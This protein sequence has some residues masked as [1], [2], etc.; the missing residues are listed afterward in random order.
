MELAELTTET[1]ILVKQRLTLADD[2]ADCDRGAFPGSAAAAK[3]NVAMAALAAFD[4]ANPS[5]REIVL[6]L[7]R[8]DRD[9][10]RDE[11]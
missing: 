2:L 10:L 1:R 9:E 4:A 5:I 8:D 11:C 6:S 7:S 3:E